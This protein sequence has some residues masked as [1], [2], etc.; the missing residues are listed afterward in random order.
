M[1]VNDHCVIS[2]YPSGMDSRTPWVKTLWMLN[3]LPSNDAP[4]A[5]AKYSEFEF[6]GVHLWLCDLT[7]FLTELASLR[8]YI[9]EAGHG[10]P[11]SPHTWED[12]ASRSRPAVARPIL[13]TKQKPPRARV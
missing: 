6:M 12:V 11:C 7:L 1:G 13:K 10:T 3:A 4:F 2:Q 9:I 8:L 5:C